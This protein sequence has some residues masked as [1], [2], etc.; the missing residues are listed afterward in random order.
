[1]NP[2]ALLQPVRQLALRAGAEIMR[3]RPQAAVRS[4]A[5]A[6]P[7]TE[8]DEAAERLIVAGLATLQPALP[9]V[10]EELMAAGATPR[11]GLAFWLVDP[12]DGTKSFIQ[13][14]DDFTVNIAL[15]EDRRPVLGVVYAPATQALYVGVVGSGASQSHDNGQ[16][17]PIQCRVPPADGLDVVVSLMHD[18]EEDIQA[19]LAGRRV[20]TTRR[21]SSSLKFCLVAAGEAD[22]Y[23]RRGETSEWDTAAGHAVLLAAGG[24]VE[25]HDGKEL[26]YSKPGF[27]N[28]GFVAQGRT[29]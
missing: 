22:L 27:R 13:G 20:R 2:G 4:K 9:V 29:S 18:R 17:H 8:A 23:P 15:I 24:R 11:T 5:D 3:L 26:L 25:T 16:M 21:L 10:A 1:M 14:R 19:L 6:S 28:P 12:L 7:V